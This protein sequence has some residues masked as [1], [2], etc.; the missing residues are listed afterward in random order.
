MSMR[1]INCRDSSQQVSLDINT[2]RL[3]CIRRVV[4]AALP[5][6]V[7]ISCAKLLRVLS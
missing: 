6:G 4:K 2:L 7:D 3:V 5:E 1:M